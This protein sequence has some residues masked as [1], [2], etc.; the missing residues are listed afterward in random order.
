MQY[1]KAIILDRRSVCLKKYI[2]SSKLPAHPSCAVSTHYLGVD[3]LQ[4]I[5][6]QNKQHCYSALAPKY[7]LRIL[8]CI[9]EMRHG[10]IN[11]STDGWL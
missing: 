11:F 1:G 3:Y 2:C 10:A 8:R 5:Q 7:T 9:N 4:A 6:A